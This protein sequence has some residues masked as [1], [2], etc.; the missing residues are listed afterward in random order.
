MAKFMWL[1][2]EKG[3]SLK[4]KI[5]H[6]KEAQQASIAT[7]TVI[8]CTNKKTSKNEIVL[9]HGHQNV[10]AQINPTT[11]VSGRIVTKSN[12]RLYFPF[13]ERKIADQRSY[14]GFKELLK[15]TE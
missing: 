3:N 4:E 9:F 15:F 11:D 12:H 10:F 6:E 5:V 2:S 8:L 13:K 14:P 7:E 1:E